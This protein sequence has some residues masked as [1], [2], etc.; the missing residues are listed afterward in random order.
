MQGQRE[1]TLG[2]P[3]QP[4]FLSD[5]QVILMPHP[6]VGLVSPPS[7]KHVWMGQ[8]GAPHLVEKLGLG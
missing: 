5:P 4:A 7:P 8:P 1:Q 3:D 6:K 2:P